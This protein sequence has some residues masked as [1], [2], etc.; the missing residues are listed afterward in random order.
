[1]QKEIKDNTIIPNK[2]GL[3]ENP[4]WSRNEV[5]EYERNNIKA[6][7]LKIKEWDYYLFNNKEYA[8]AFT[9]SDLG[10][11]GLL[12]VSLIDFIN[13][14]EITKT[15]LVWFPK[16]KVFNLGKYVKDCKGECHTKNLDMFFSSSGDKKRHISCT[17]KN[18]KNSE[19]FKVE[20]DI[21]EPDM[22]AMYICTPWKK[23][24]KAFYYNC[25][26][27]CLVGEGKATLGNLEIQ[28][29]KEECFGVLDWGR[30][31]WTY[32]NTWYWGTG[33]GKINNELFGFNLGYG[34]SDRS[35][36]TENVIYYKDKVHKLEDVFFT[37]PQENGKK[38]Y[39]EKWHISSNNGRFEAIFEPIIDRKAKMNYVLILTDQ[40]QVFGKMSGYCILDDNT[41][42]E[43]KDFICALEEVRNKY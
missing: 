2:D 25:K 36:C 32:D 11:V 15:D 29:K 40:H 30:G 7:A 17:Y 42:L 35:S 18:F 43:F 37:I 24:R 8:V 26:K 9:I 27:N 34:F 6:G 33:S 28:F 3:I 31:V 12:S 5:M 16:G 39:I 23:N 21:Y 13:K 41:K 14:E 1:M 38:K 22:E 19:T 10:Y 4:G 20:L